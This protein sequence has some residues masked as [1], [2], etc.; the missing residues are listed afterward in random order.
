MWTADYGTAG[1]VK[2]AGPRKDVA[3]EQKDVDAAGCVHV[4]GWD[5]PTAAQAPRM[6]LVV[7]RKSKQ[8]LCVC[9][10]FPYH[11]FLGAYLHSGNGR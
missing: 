4:R 7:Q 8:S 2:Q 11:G 5:F 6:M 3:L 9:S 10:P 1:R